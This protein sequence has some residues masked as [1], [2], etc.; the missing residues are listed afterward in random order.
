MR[1]TGML[2][3][4]HC[5]SNSGFAI[6]R[7]ERVFWEVARRITGNE[8]KIVFAYPGFRGDRPAALPSY[9]ENVIEFDSTSA[10]PTRIRE[11]A[12]YLKERD[13]RIALGFDQQVR[14]PG[15]SALRR[16]G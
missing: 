11:V 10:D 3:F 6:A 1:M 13:V 7:L 5:P 2:I 16:G 12:G 15:Y 8:E 9:F 14:L 4:F